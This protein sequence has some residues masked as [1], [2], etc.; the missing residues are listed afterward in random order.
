MLFFAFDRPVAHAHVPRPLCA[1]QDHPK[2]ERF[3]NLLAM[4]VPIGQIQNVMESVGLDVA[5]LS[6]PEKLIPL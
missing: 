5:L 6:E 2:Y 3:F 1:V 4:R